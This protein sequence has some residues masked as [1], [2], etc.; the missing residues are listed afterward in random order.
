M[1]TLLQYRFVTAFA[2]LATLV[3]SNGAQ[4]KDPTLLDKVIAKGEIRCG[5]VVWPPTTIKDPNT[6]K[7]SGIFPEVLEKVAE[8][9]GLKLVWVEEASYGTAIEGMNTKRYDMICSVIWPNTNRALHA[10]FSTPLNYSAIEAF[11]RTDESRIK[12]IED[13]NNPDV[14]I[15]TIDGE[16]AQALAHSDFP[17]AK[18]SGLPQM[19]AYGQLYT[20]VLSKKSDVILHDLVTA[21]DFMTKNPGKL[22]RLAPGKPL[23]VYPN[24]YM[25]P[26]GEEEFRDFLN[27]ALQE[28]INSGYVATIVKKYGFKE[29]TY[30]V[31]LPYA[32]N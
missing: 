23:R 17:K 28:L 15:S 14:T 20:E 6:G 21:Q 32:P 5:Y 4:A 31:A 10:S 18:T 27:L 13:I 7:V 16:S 24:T 2:L 30:P 25:L 26:K 12:K 9:A 11:V 29:G 3:L 22:K 19:T 8:N 1:K